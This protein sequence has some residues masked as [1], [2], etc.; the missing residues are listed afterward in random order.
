M[1]SSFDEIPTRAYTAVT[2]QETGSD[3]PSPAKLDD[4][5]HAVAD[6]HGFAFR[7]GIGAV[8]SL[9]AYEYGYCLPSGGYIDRH[10]IE[11]LRER[12]IAAD[13]TDPWVRFKSMWVSGDELDSMDLVGTPPEVALHG[14]IEF[15]EDFDEYS[16]E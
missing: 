12:L 11:S 6:I 9:D 5:D 16:D 2:I 15:A 7:F 10:R 14:L 4:I 13:V 3:P 8:T 1:V